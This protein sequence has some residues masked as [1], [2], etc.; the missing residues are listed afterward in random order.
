MEQQQSIGLSKAA[1]QSR[2]KRW[3]EIHF[4]YLPTFTYEYCAMRELHAKRWGIG[5][6]FLFM[7]A[8]VLVFA[9]IVV[10][11]AV[12]LGERGWLAVA[13]EGIG[14]WLL[15]GILASVLPALQG[16]Q[17][18][19]RRL[20]SPSSREKLTFSINTREIAVRGETIRSYLPW[21]AVSKVSETS[22]FF[23]VYSA[24]RLAYS[25]SKKAMGPAACDEF[26][27]LVYSL[28]GE[29]AAAGESMPA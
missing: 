12:L 17:V 1:E 9:L 14:W 24:S 23:H 18:F 5:L 26:R 22:D 21:E 3:I 29:R 8:A 16:G 7:S 2:S 28:F 20:S 10:F 25:I 4:S 19:L 15:P 11:A 27:R 6:E 13:K